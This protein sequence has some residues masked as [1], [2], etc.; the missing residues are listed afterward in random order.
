MDPVRRRRWIGLGALLAAALAVRVGLPTSASAPGDVVGAVERPQTARAPESS[1]DAVAASQWSF[2]RPPISTPPSDPFAP[3][4]LPPPQAPPP[5]VAVEAPRPSA[6]PLPFKFMG[7]LEGDH[8]NA[9]F[10]TREN[11]VLTIEPGEQIEEHYRVESIGETEIVF[12]YLPLAE[13]QVLP[14]R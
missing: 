5:P 10:V 7:R 14:I 9:V 8:V 11:R 1:A 3:R 6:P 13:R 2:D 4:A 12:S